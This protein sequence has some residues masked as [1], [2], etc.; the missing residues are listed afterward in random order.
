MAIVPLGESVMI[1]GLGQGSPLQ[2]ASEL[3]GAPVVKAHIQGDSW[4]A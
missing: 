2:H 4:H 1:D 3:F